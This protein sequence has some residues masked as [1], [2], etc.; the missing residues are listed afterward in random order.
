MRFTLLFLIISFRNY[1]LLLVV[2]MEMFAQPHCFAFPKMRQHNTTFFCGLSNNQI[3]ICDIRHQS[4]ITALHG[5]DPFEFSFV[6]H[7]CPVS[8][9]HFIPNNEYSLVS[10]SFDGTVI[11]WDVRLNLKS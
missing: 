5:F 1:Q 8:S 9:V 4:N 10:T 3:R 7:E 2:T 6:G 11:I